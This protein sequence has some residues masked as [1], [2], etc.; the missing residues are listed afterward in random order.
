MYVCMYSSELTQAQLNSMKREQK[1]QYLGVLKTKA[2]VMFNEV[3]PLHNSDQ[4]VTNVR[5]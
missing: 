4:P 2:K 3:G 1:S 5:G